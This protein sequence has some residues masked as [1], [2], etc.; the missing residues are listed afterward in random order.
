M[1][2]GKISTMQKLQKQTISKPSSFA[3]DLPFKHKVFQ[4][5]IN[6]AERLQKTV[7]RKKIEKHAIN[8]DRN[9]AVAL[10]PG[11][12]HDGNT[13]EILGNGSSS[14]KSSQREKNSE[15]VKTAIL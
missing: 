14:E 7:L 15:I 10:L 13:E 9:D 6:K 1:D 2:K 11:R 12:N 8:D 3:V 4:D 5:I